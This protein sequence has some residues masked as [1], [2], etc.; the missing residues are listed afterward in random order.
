METRIRGQEVID[1]TQEPLQSINSEV[2]FQI[3]AYDLSFELQFDRIKK[4]S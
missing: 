3:D 4:R 1:L 2:G